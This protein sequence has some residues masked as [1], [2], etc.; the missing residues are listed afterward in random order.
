MKLIIL[1]ILT[2]TSLVA[3][4]TVH[5]E[6]EPEIKWT[7]GVTPDHPCR[8]NVAFPYAEG[9]VTLGGDNGG[10]VQMYYPASGTWSLLPHMPAARMFP[11]A[12]AINDVIYVIGGIDTSGRYL[13]SV[14]RYEPSEDGWLTCS[15]LETGLSRHAVVKAENEIYVTG[16]LEGVSDREYANSNRLL[17]YSAATDSWSE[18]APMPTARHGHTAVMVHGSIFVAGGFNATGAT[19][20]HEA[21]DLSRNAWYSLPEL[22]EPLG[23]HG[24]VYM[25]GA[26]YV[27]AGRVGHER[28]SVSRYDLNSATW[29]ALKP[30]PVWLNRFGCT[31][32]GERVY[33]VG[34]EH[35]PKQ[36]LIGEVQP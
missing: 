28:G 20:V 33:V 27:I 3:W 11:G 22:P 35:Q 15:P 10:V 1:I 2:G 29:T 4:L 9:F 12:T 6:P 8:Y 31:A 36:F 24:A 30:F 17:V 19:G 32:L 23:F 5:L 21:Y 25:D 34:G 14:L 16:G 26:I 7:E 18:E 13:S